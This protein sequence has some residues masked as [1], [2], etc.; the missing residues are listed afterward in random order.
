M[1]AAVAGGGGGVRAGEGEGGAQAAQHK[2][3]RT[4]KVQ[5]ALPR[6][7]LAAL[8]QVAP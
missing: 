3:G 1:A 7:D 6:A 8:M 5:A 4:L 2:T